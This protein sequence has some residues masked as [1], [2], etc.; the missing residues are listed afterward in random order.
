MKIKIKDFKLK[1][2]IGI[3]DWEKKFER[4][5]LIN[6]II[7]IS[8]SKSTIS[9]LIDD[10]VDYELIYNQIKNLVETKRYNLIEKLAQEIVDL[11]M[12]DLRIDKVSIEIDKMNIFEEVKSCAVFIEK[13]RN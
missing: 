2:N 8:N 1:T 6:I 12:Q 13:Y 3:Y 11:I 9:D 4:E 10:T 7:D 5:I